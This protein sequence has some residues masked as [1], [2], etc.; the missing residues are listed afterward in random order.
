MS[1]RLSF[2]ENEPLFLWKLFFGFLKVILVVFVL[3]SGTLILAQSTV[4]PVSVR[5]L[6]AYGM[7]Y[8]VGKL[9]PLRPFFPE[10]Y[11]IHTK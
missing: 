8:A 11:T 9:K 1:T 3:V 10:P 7:E 2:D 5:L 4:A 6:C